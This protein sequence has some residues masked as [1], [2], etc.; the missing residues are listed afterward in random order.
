MRSVRFLT[1]LGFLLLVIFWAST[2]P[3][4]PSP[5]LTTTPSPR[6]NPTLGAAGPAAADLTRIFTVGTR[7]AMYS[8]PQ[9]GRLTREDFEFLVKSIRKTQFAAENVQVV[10][11]IHNSGI[12]GTIGLVEKRNQRLT[13][14]FITP[15]GPSPFE[16]WH[17]VGYR[18]NPEKILA[19]YQ[20][21][22]LAAEETYHDLPLLFTGITKRVAKDNRGRVF[23]EFSLNHSDLTLA[24]YP[25]PESPQ[26]LDL[27]NLKTGQH[28]DVSGQ[29][30]EYYIGGLK[31][32]NCLFSR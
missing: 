1:H 24:C 5:F 14:A 30:I 12:Q 10:V 22:I 28:I 25:W 23:V 32:R 17:R 20:E 7:W 3:A 4:Q 6:S 19:D 13:S 2:A 31:L 11:I 26:G 8:A 29:F 16:L 18:C 21:N 27:K 9:N 15:N